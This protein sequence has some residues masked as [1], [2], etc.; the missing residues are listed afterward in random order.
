MGRP[1]A[2]V[3]TEF[4][5][6]N[7]KV[8][9]YCGGPQPLA[10]L[11]TVGANG[12][13]PSNVRGLPAIQDRDGLNPQCRPTKGCGTNLKQNPSPCRSKVLELIENPVIVNPKPYVQGPLTLGRFEA[14]FPQNINKSK[15]ET[16]STRQTLHGAL[17]ANLELQRDS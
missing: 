8:G 9:A 14:L 16:S 13:Q 7:S 4:Q 5:I 6:T 1:E 10:G 3:R 2:L 12:R 17:E 15:S 11:Q